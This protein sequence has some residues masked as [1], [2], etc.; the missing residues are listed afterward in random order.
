[1]KF[2]DS[3][4]ERLK[5][6]ADGNR[7]EFLGYVVNL[8]SGKIVDSLKENGDVA[9]LE[10]EVLQVL[11]E[12]YAK[13]EPVDRAGILM[14]FAC[15][16]GGYAYDK[17]FLQ[18]AV[19]PVAEAFGDEPERLVECAKRLGGFAVSFGDCAVEVPALLRIPL[20]IVVWR[21]S[22]FP[23]QAS[24]LYDQTANNYLPTEDLAV[25]GELTTTRLIQTLNKD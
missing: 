10:F 24:I 11:L 9:K 13:A 18:R 19:Q 5:R 23:A 3:E 21:R 2:D 20:T 7:L 14:K 16:P 1:V 8:D 22:E 6:L 17:A 15:L 4:V 25:L 12:H